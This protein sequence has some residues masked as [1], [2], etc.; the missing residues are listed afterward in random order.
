MPDS[1]NTG[2]VTKMPKVLVALLCYN[3]CDATEQIL[4]KFPKERNYEVLLVNDGS[5]DNTSNILKKHNFKIIE[6]HVNKGLGA[7][8]KTALRYARDNQHDIIVIMAG[9]G[10]D[11][12]QE[13]PSVVRPI[14]EGKAD[15]V[16]GSRFLK[17]GAW[18]NLPL[19]RFIM[20]KLYGFM[21][22]FCTGITVTDPLNGFRAY[23]L[24]I[25]KDK[26]INVWQDWLDHY[27]Y[28]TYLNYNVLRLGYRYQELPVSKLYP[29]RGKS[30]KTVK[31][32]HIRPFVDWWSILRPI[33]FLALRV[34]K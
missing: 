32:T 16:Q 17:G 34:K 4:Q 11:N 12:P 24:D 29:T 7:A 10:K 13:I 14:L 22:T 31:Y 1:Q 9:N 33:F 23:R 8:I 2:R 19:F 15:Y 25:F 6:H 26:R 30:S 20:I 18:D 3:T 28:E 27:E 5:V 21:L